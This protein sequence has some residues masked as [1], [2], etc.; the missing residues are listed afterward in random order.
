MTSDH[1]SVTRAVLGKPGC[2]GTLVERAAQLGTS[3][4]TQ[5]GGHEGK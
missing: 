4:N 1:A 5:S 2:M 3:R